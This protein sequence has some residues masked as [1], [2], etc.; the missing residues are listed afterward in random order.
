ML[1]AGTRILVGITGGIA[2]Y[3]SVLLIREL[4]KRDVEVRAIATPSTHHFIGLETLRAITRHEVPTDVFQG[5]EA[6]SSSWTRHIHWAEWADLFVIAPCTANTLAKLANGFSDNMLTSTAL[7][8]RCPILLCP[9]MD[10]DMLSNPSTQRNLA[11]LQES[12]IHILPPD[13][14]YLASGLVG[15]G[16]LPETDAILAKIEDI[17]TDTDRSEKTFDQKDTPNTSASVTSPTSHIPSVTS[18]EEH[19]TG[20]LA[21]KHV[22]V[23]AGPTR[24]PVD[25]VR[26]LS[27]PSTGKMGI[28][29]ARAAQLAGAEV[30]L[31]LGPTGAQD[32]A[33]IR[34]I[35]FTTAEDLFEKAKSLH[36]NADIIIKTAAVADFRPVN[37]S[38]LKTPK[39]EMNLTIELEPTQDIL[40]WLSENRPAGQVLIGFAMQTTE[41]LEPARRK[42][43]QKGLDA[44]L[45]NQLIEGKTGFATDSNVLTLLTEYGTERTFSGYKE[46]IAQQ[47]LSEIFQHAR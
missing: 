32:P 41:N 45:V 40:A 39:T 14:G 13:D 31:L 27:N 33:G 8:S 24:E 30:T 5:A 25:A 34:T 37:P 29:M 9:T 36:Q 22:L 11:K 3:K 10:G 44:I 1:R 26:F 42:R 47:I 35:R 21:G 7:A 28:A 15:P 4:Q 19:R 18:T 23:T 16:R 17:L 6:G 46:D 2:A 12:G 43:E 38:A 20:Y